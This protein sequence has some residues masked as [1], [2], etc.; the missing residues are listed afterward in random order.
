MRFVC[1]SVA[2]SALLAG[3]A[4][5]VLFAEGSGGGGM[6]T[7]YQLAAPSGV[8]NYAPTGS[9]PGLSYVGGFG[10][11]VDDRGRISGGFGYAVVGRSDERGIKGGM[12]GFISGYRFISQPF[13]LSLV[14]WTGRLMPVLFV[15]YQVIGN[16][17]PGP[18][19][20]SSFTLAP[21]AGIRLTWGTFR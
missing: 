2:L 6:T 9:G 20:Q 11:R 21:T 1:T 19:F 10:Y 12:A 18:V 16:L 17:A 7:S 4:S 3:V 5:G 15:G 8:L 13:N 14:S